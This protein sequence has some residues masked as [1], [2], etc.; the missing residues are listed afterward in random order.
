[1]INNLRVSA[2]PKENG[3]GVPLSYDLNTSFTKKKKKKGKCS[4]NYECKSFERLLA[5]LQY[6]QPTSCSLSSCSE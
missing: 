6:I 4:P 5:R 3:G 2:E 1:M